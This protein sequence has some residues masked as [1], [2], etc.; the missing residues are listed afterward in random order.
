MADFQPRVVRRLLLAGVPAFVIV[1]A[2]YVHLTGGRYISTDNAYVKAHIVRVSPEVDGQVSEVN[3]ANNMVVA[4]GDILFRMDDARFQLDLAAANAEVDRVRQMLASLKARYAQ[5]QAELKRAEERIRFFRV[6]LKRQ[7]ELKTGGFSSGSKFDDAE[8]EMIMST[9]EAA[10]LRE[11]NRMTLSE[12][13]GKIDSPVEAHARFRVAIAKRERAALDLARATVRAPVSGILGN[14]SLRPGEHVTQGRPVL[15]LVAANGYWL[16]VNLK[17]VYMTN[18]R[19]GQPASV[20]LDAYPNF[21]WKAKVESISPTTGSEFSLLPAQ[22]ASGNWVKVVQRIPL[23]LKIIKP[24]TAAPPLRVGMTAH[25]SIDTGTDRLSGA[26]AQTPFPVKLAND[27]GP[28]RA[29]VSDP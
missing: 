7:K 25:V 19:V 13:G 5:E 11:R 20:V 26:S 3:A 27:T 12:L 1:A 9:Q 4:K 23:R 8:H 22:N 28:A 18:V 15:A 21:E 2:G 17:E 24:T 10:A 16:Q 29:V 6:R 14:V